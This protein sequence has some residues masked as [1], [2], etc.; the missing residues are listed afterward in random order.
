MKIEKLYT[1]SQF[2]D[3]MGNSSQE[4][5]A[6]GSSLINVL[7]YNKF[8]KKPLK[9]EM[10]INKCGDKPRN[11]FWAAVPDEY[12]DDIMKWEGYEEKM[13]F[14]GCFQ[15]DEDFGLMVRA[16]DNEFEILIP[17]S[18]WIRLKTLHDLA[19]ATNGEL[20]LKNVE[21]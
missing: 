15:W 12:I 1:L 10:F 11:N 20:K 9:K 2:V 18:E 5:N 21:L 14:E 4:T 6:I 17:D 19:E 7:N 8:L 3:L 13:I 16:D